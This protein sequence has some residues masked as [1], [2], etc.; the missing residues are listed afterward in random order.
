MRSHSF[1]DLK[2]HEIIAS[3]PEGSSAPIPFVGMTLAPMEYTAGRKDT[4]IALVRARFARP[5][6]VVEPRINE[7]FPD[8]GAGKSP[9]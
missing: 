1:L 5:R 6:S 7:L 8:F 2:K 4:I 3:I 9:P